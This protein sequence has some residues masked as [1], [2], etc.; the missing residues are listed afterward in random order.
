M[1]FELP[2]QDADLELNT[3]RSAGLDTKHAEPAISSSALSSSSSM[4]QIQTE[5]TD[6]KSE[7]IAGL[8]DEPDRKL[9]LKSKEQ[10]IITMS[11]RAAMQSMLIQNALTS[12]TE[13]QPEIKLKHLTVDTLQHV[14]R[15]LEYHVDHPATPISKPLVS[16]D[17]SL[18]LC[19][20]D[21]ELANFLTETKNHDILF[22]ML[23]AANFM[24]IKPLTE[25]CAAAIASLMK[26]KTPEEIRKTFGLSEKP[27]PEEEEQVKRDFK[28]LLE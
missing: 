5:T 11:Y 10:K 14:A 4:P 17:L 7:T 2:T 1:N 13:D 8:D 16:P 20:W 21:L 23:L 6:E 27:T 24:D 18:V 12:N 25:F 19:P 22:E 26:N 15:Y 9:N 28:D 3:P